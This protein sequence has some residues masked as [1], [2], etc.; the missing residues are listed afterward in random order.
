[1]FEMLIIKV[2][3]SNSLTQNDL[4]FNLNEGIGFGKRRVLRMTVR[5][6]QNDTSYILPSLPLW[7]G[8]G[9]LLYLLSSRNRI[10][11]IM[12][13]SEYLFLHF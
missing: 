7:E 4:F 1:V 6:V 5:Q 13:T 10:L 9:L 2:K 8:D 11:Q 12:K 3:N